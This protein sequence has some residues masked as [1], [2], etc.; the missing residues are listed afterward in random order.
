[1]SPTAAGDDESRSPASENELELEHA[2][3]PRA[4]NQQLPTLHLTTA[5]L[6][7]HMNMPGVTMS[8]KA[9]NAGSAPL[10]SR[11]GKSND[12]N[13]EMEDAEHEVDDFT[14]R[15]PKK[16][17]RITKTTDK[18]Y[19]CPQPDCGKAYSR[20]EHL[21]RHQLNRS[22]SEARLRHFDVRPGS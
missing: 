3:Q 15:K 1:M 4:C 19:E 21:Y 6:D 20:A 10:E 12:E 13:V 18:K 8:A 16:K 22:Y 11:P 2:D 17:R 14:T 9:E 7:D 5:S